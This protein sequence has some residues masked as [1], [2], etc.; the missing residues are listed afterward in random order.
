MKAN[1]IKATSNMAEAAKAAH[2]SET[3]TPDTIQWEPWNLPDLA[4]QIAIRLL[5]A[6]RTREGLAI[7]EDLVRRHPNDPE[8]RQ[9]LGLALSDSGSN[10]EALP[11]LRRAVA[12]MPGKAAPLVA[13]GAVLARSHAHAEAQAVLE[14]A[15][16][17]DPDS[18]FGLTNLAACLL[19]AGK[20]PERAE[21]LLRRADRLMPGN[22][23]VWLNLGEA[24][25]KQ[26]RTA[27]AEQAFA[28][29]IEISP[30]GNM[31]QIIALKRAELAREPHRTPPTSKA[32]D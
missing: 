18:A 26:G 7:M 1:R 9:T 13:L 32:H 6:A 19:A 22:T 24:L 27:E 23:S 15:L 20:S 5:T 3:E 12:E 25:W 29:A 4:H 11:H 17:I 21:Q 28:R 16:E 31:A 2:E 30:R 14:K 8:L 10:E